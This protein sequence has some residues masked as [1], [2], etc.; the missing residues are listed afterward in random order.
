MIA[1]GSVRMKRIYMLALA[2]CML[3]SAASAHA[4]YW[5]GDVQRT[6]YCREAHPGCEVLQMVMMG[7]FAE[8]DET[9]RLS[10]RVMS[11]ALAQLSAVTEEDVAHFHA[12]FDVEEDVLRTNYY[13]ALGNSLLSDILLDPGQE[14]QEEQV[15]RVLRLF[16]N[17]SAE[18]NAQLQMDVIRR[19]ADQTLIDLMARTVNLP[20]EFIAYVIGYPAESAEESVQE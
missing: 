1:E 13:I 5:A 9:D 18:W 12:D 17:P 19:Q 20:S 7:S 16:L 11:A 3:L 2:A 4:E 6:V 15:R 14:G 8:V 10:I